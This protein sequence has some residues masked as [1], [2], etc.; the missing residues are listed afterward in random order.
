MFCF[1]NINIEK[2]IN[3]KIEAISVLI[4]Q[5]KDLIN[6]NKDKIGEYLRDESYFKL[7]EEELEKRKYNFEDL[8][9][10]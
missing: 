6:A 7:M 5:Y 8:K 2:A 10:I 3:R 4:N 1:F 9:L